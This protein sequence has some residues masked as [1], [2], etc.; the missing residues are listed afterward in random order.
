MDDNRRS[1]SPPRMSPRERLLLAFDLYEAGE[2][3]MR[4]KLRREHPLASPEEI[5]RRIISWLRSG[6][7]GSKR[8]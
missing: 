4:L 7:H 6:R 3:M 8:R 5:E 1:D 2:Q